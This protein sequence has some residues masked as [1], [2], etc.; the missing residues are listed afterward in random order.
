MRI[1]GFVVHG[2]VTVAVFAAGVGA[3]VTGAG[4]PGVTLAGPQVLRLIQNSPAALASYPAV[5]MTFKISVSA[6]GQHFSSTTHGLLS[7]DGKSGTMSTGLPNGLGNLTFEAVDNT[8]YIHAAPAEAAVLGKKWVGFTLT[9]HPGGSLTQPSPGTDGLGFLH[10]MPGATGQVQDLGHSRIGGVAATHYRVTIDVQKALASE[11]AEMR[12]SSAEELQSA[13]I[14][15]EPVDVWLDAQGA[16]RQ[17]YW[18]AT[19]QGAH[20]EF[21]LQLSGSKK[22][23]QVTAPPASDVQFVSTVTELIRDAIQR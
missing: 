13:G 20:A 21:R 3:A 1:N 9:S 5:N 7:P 14:S 23:V 6:Q 12:T 8:M 16:P 2:A 15:M 22:A 19:S 10:L 17:L 4:G 11:P 18:E